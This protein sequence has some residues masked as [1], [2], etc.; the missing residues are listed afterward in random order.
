M[1]AN[2][3]LKDKGNHEGPTTTTK[4]MTATT[5]KNDSPCVNAGLAGNDGGKKNEEQGK[6]AE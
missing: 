5:K 4:T 6:K 2:V 3:M 1:R